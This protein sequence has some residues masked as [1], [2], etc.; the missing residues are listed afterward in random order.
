MTNADREML[1]GLRE[2][3]NEALRGAAPGSEELKGLL[4]VIADQIYDADRR[5]SEVLTE[6]RDRLTALSE[7]T[8]AVRTQVS[9]DLG[10]VF[11]RIED[12]LSQLA[13]RMIEPRPGVDAIAPAF[14]TARE[15]PSPAP[16]AL[17]SAT[18]PAQP[19]FSRGAESA[20]PQSYGQSVDTFD[21]VDVSV[22][23]A[24]PVDWDAEQAE[25]LTRIYEDDHCDAEAASPADAAPALSAAAVL[26]EAQPHA[27]AR[28]VER[29][30]LEAK[31][32]EIAERIEQSFA[33]LTPE[34]PI[35]SLSE[36]FD[37]LEQ[38]FGDALHDVATR[39]DVEA[40]HQLEGQIAELAAQV[41]QAHLQFTRLDMI[42]QQISSVIEHM[43]DQHLAAQPGAHALDTEA[44]ER[45]AEMA[46]RHVADRLVMPPTGSEETATREVRSLL[47]SF[48]VERRQGDEHTMTMLDTLQQALI[49]ILDRVDAIE[50]AQHV[51][52]HAPSMPVHVVHSQPE[53]SDRYAAREAGPA[54]G[55][56]DDHSTAMHRE[57][58][59]GPALEEPAF[60]QHAHE[61]EAM[62]AGELEAAFAGSQ[63][64]QSRVEPELEIASAPPAPAAKSPIDKLRQDFI[65]DA[66]RAKLKAAAEQAQAAKAP[67]GGAASAL[68]GALASTKDE[69]QGAR[70][71]FGLSPKLLVVALAAIVAING[72]MLM[73]SGGSGAP[74]E[75]PA[76]AA[77]PSPPSAGGDAA[78]A[79]ALKKP[80]AEAQPENGVLKP[81]SD[82]PGRGSVAGMVEGGIHFD[83]ADEHDEAVLPQGAGETVAGLRINAADQIPSAEDFARIRQQQN[84]ARL[85]GQ[86]GAHTAEY[87]TPAAFLEADESAETDGVAPPAE[88]GITKPP[89]ASSNL[90]LPPVTVGPLSLRLAAAK[91]DP[92][93]Q[94]EVAARLAEGKGTAQNFKEAMRWYQ[95]SAAQ[96]FAQAQ[97]RLGTLFE[98]GLGTKADAAFAREWYERAAQQGNVKAMHNLAVLSAMSPQG[99]PDYETAAGWFNKAADRGLQDSQYNLAVLYESGLGLA[100]D[101][102]QAC[103]WYILAARGGDK[104]AVRRRDAAKAQ[105]APQEIAEAEALARS[106]APIATDLLVNDARAAGED[107]KRRQVETGNG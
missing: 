5:H 66:Q 27:G 38:R 49:R 59:Y 71:L 19:M 20:R 74:V 68:R 96:G 77:E 6:M 41:E 72:A 21:V 13:D 85:S 105:L 39:S 97:Y 89:A 102:K 55:D 95:R 90:E 22:P 107:W 18:V 54:R 75:M 7:D 101:M 103:K 69:S 65:A 12:A 37:L 87:M 31:F 9:G 24:S 106:F 80:A 93:A 81:R 28:G 16:A 35:E 88:G 56:F 44:M 1:A 43:S 46:A 11:T 82:L 40:L 10:P 48:I 26:N 32:A 47:E 84:L 73:F 70:K 53:M 2:D 61:R 34:S 64:R 42:E 62:I 67:A 100:K 15:L 36:R 50:M 17:K 33:T 79:P 14:E 51:G 104:E 29:E 8:R 58:S 4:G 63:T 99:S 60:A 52:Q 98:R 92:S 91:G 76:P 57:P 94:F 30:W 86:V 83:T 25:A 23:A 45:V 3:A 78:P